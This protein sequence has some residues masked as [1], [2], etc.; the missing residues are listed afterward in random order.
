MSS[1][2]T[3]TPFAPQFQTIAI[4]AATT[5]PLGV[6]CGPVAGF[7]PNFQIFNAG[8]VAV[9]LAY[10]TT[11]AAAQ[12]AAIAPVPG[13]PQNSVIVPAGGWLTMTFPLG[14]YISG[15]TLTGTALV[16]VTAG[17]GQ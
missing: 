15:I 17:T 1:D 2:P 3:L 9:F 10:G 5:A 7:L 13:T 14:S 6:Q 12:S 11:G 4:L 8:T 16:Y